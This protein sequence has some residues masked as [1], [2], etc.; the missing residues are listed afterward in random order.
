VGVVVY[1]NEVDWQAI[2]KIEVKYVLS[3]AAR[4][5]PLKRIEKNIRKKTDKRRARKDF[6]KRRQL[7]L[8]QVLEASKLG[9]QAVED[10]ARKGVFAKTLKK[11][12]LGAK[13]L[14]ESGVNTLMLR[15]LNFGI[16]ELV[17]LE[18]N[19]INLLNAGF[20]GSELKSVNIG[21][22]QLKHGVEPERLLKLF[23]V[24][25]LLDAG[26]PKEQ[27]LRVFKKRKG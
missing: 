23:S 26:I 14:K 25:D 19:P 27:I 24:K 4:K 12:D 17:P 22:A 9:P 6:A 15:L 7:L 13:N 5:K 8:D 10:L 11:H 2:K 21:P 16:K 18:S 1:L 3:M 20:G